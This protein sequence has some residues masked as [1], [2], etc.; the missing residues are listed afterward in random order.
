MR[1]T[2][3]KRITLGFGFAI[4]L[5]MSLSFA[6]YRST[7]SFQEIGDQ[8]QHSYQVLLK[9]EKVIDHLVDAETW[10]RGYIITGGESY[11]EPYRTATSR[12]DGALRE[13][14]TLTINNPAQQVRLNRLDSLIRAKLD[15]LAATIVVRKDRGFDEA[16]RAIIT[17]RGKRLMDETRQVLAEIEAMQPDGTARDPNQLELF[18]AM[19]TEL[20]TMQRRHG[21]LESHAVSTLSGNTF[22]GTWE[23]ILL[24][25][26]AS[27]MAWAECTLGEFML[28]LALDGRA[29]TGVVIPVTTPEAFLRGS[30]EAGVVRIIL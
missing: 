16:Q 28:G 22:R 13:L 25:F 10:Q 1:L 7:R 5:L 23:E 27:E 17:D 2:I 9:L 3:S 26:K 29:Q 30:A 20:Q 6:S 12:V 21:S 18:G 4:L 15:E 19:L 14:Q 24:Q 8:R 11:L